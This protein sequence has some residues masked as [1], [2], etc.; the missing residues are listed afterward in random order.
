MQLAFRRLA[1]YWLDFVLLAAVLIG[2]QFLLY[3]VTSG[4]PFDRLEKGY[5]IELWVL[6]AMSLPTWLYFIGCEKYRGQ[7]LGKRLLKLKV[8]SLPAGGAITW[9][10]AVKRTFVKLLPWELTHLIILVPDP[11]WS[12]EEPANQALI[13]IPNLLMVVY[14]GFLFIT[15]GM[16]GLQDVWAKTRVEIEK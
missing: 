8:S 9:G 5:Q 6:A 16:K 4:F 13:Y 14:I 12:V 2:G 15:K 11:W 7:T 10:Q 3:V 1:A